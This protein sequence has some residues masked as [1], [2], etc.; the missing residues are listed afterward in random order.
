M[1]SVFLVVALYRTDKLGITGENIQKLGVITQLIGCYS[2]PYVILADWNVPPEI[3]RRSGW[4]EAV[5]GDI[6]LADNADITCRG[7]GGTCIDYAV[8]SHN[9][10]GF[11]GGFYLD[12]DSPWLPHVGLRLVLKGSP[13]QLR[14]NKL[15]SPLYL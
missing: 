6:I 4:L 12:C 15:R 11:I 9:M 1:G 14:M 7:G 5:A 13:H 10:H 3:L 2:L 8:I